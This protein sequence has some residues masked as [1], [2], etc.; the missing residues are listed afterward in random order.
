MLIFLMPPLLAPPQ[1]DR[2]G[3]TSAKQPLRYSWPSVLLCLWPVTRKWTGLSSPSWK[4]KLMRYASSLFAILW[5]TEWFRSGSHWYH[6]WALQGNFPFCLSL[7]L[8][9]SVRLMS[10]NESDVMFPSSSGPSTLASE[11]DYAAGQGFILLDDVA[12]VGTELSLLDCP[13]SNW[14]QHDCSHAEDVGVRCSLESNTVMDGSL[15]NSPCFLPWA[16]GQCHLVACS[17]GSSGRCG[18]WEGCFLRR[19]IRNTPWLSW[20]RTVAPP[21]PWP[22]QQRNWNWRE[23][24]VSKTNLRG[25]EMVAALV[26]HC[27]LMRCLSPMFVGTWDPFN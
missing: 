10:F 12:C 27:S 9:P 8:I 22:A 23:L 1:T 6:S 18:R 11:G 20:S 14:G 21:D 13:H 24:A 7:C 5:V 16:V 2:P 25:W 15:G 4:L 17:L 3:V 26:C 19:N